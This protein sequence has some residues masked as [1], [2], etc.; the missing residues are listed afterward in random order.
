M[1]SE[2]FFKVIGVY[3]SRDMCNLHKSDCQEHLSYVVKRCINMIIL[4]SNLLYYMP[5]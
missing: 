3:C 1:Y 5:S 4:S 2:Q